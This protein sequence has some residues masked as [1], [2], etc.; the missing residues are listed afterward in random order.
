MKHA[1]RI[2]DPATGLPTETPSYSGVPSAEAISEIAGPVGVVA[3]V[4]TGSLPASEAEALSQEWHG[5][6]LKCAAASRKDSAEGRETHAWCNE[7]RSATYLLCADELRQRA[8]LP[9]S[10]QPEENGEVCDVPDRRCG[11]NQ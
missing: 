3:A 11:I 6:S 8:G 9:T 4:A 7:V 2:L 1:Y 10:R 5:R